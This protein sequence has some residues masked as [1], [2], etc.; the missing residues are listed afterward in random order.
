MKEKWKTKLLIPV[1]LLITAIAVGVT[2][3]ALLFR[4][5]APELSPDYAPREAEEHAEL[6]DAETEEK[7]VAT[8]GGGAVSMIYQKEVRISLSDQQ[9]RL[10]FQNPSKSVNDIVLQLAIVGEDGTETIIAQSGTLHPGYQVEQ[11]ELIERA[12]SLSLGTYT[13]KYNVLYYDPDTAEKA[14]LNGNIEGIEITV[15]E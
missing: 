11:L 2:L 3:W 13:G 12:A 15:T 4:D 9:A 6:V 7:M 14:V 1:L 10:M 8:K 5:T